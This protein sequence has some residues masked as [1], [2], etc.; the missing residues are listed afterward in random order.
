MM[1]SAIWRVKGISSQN[2]LPHASMTCGKLDG[3]KETPAAITSNVARSAKTNA[4]GT[5]RSVQSVN[6]RA[7]RARNPGRSGEVASGE[8]REGGRVMEAEYY[9]KAKP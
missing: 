4:S 7:M 2:P 8:E 6:A 3:V 5:Q 1:T 9:H